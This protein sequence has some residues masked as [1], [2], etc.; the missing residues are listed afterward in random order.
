MNKNKVLIALISFLI[1]TSI[2]TGCNN[3]ESKLLQSNQFIKSNEDEVNFI[4]VQGA[5][6][7]GIGITV[8][9]IE[10]KDKI[11]KVVEL[12]SDLKIKKLSLKEQNDILDDGKKLSK[13]GNYAITLE[14]NS[15]IV[16]EVI[17]LYDEEKIL[18]YDIDTITGDNNKSVSYIGSGKENDKVKTIM[19]V[20]LEKD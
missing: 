19:N 11:K 3:N 8:A 6:D 15:K 9:K 18:F 12:L 2:F 4:Q 16:G 1:V 7:N 20:L 17:V 5:N 14:S 13:A 10:D